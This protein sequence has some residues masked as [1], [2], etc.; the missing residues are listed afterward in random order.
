MASHHEGTAVA[1]QGLSELANRGHVEVIGRLV[2]Q[3]ELRRG[4]A[5]NKGGERGQHGF[6]TGQSRHRVIEAQ[7]CMGPVI[8]RRR[9]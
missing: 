9:L 3:Q 4:S 5:R 7:V 8:P 6:A 2:E 1:V